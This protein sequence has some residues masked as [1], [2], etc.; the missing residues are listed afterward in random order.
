MGELFRRGVSMKKKCLEKLVKKGLMWAKM[1]K[2]NWKQI[3]TEIKINK[4]KKLKE[5]NVHNQLTKAL[6]WVFDVQCDKYY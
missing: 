4:E 5:L 1:S 6:K 2:N 3:W